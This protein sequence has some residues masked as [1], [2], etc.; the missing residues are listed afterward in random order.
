MAAAVTAVSCDDNNLDDGS[1]S[2]VTKSS[3]TYT[4]ALNTSGA[5][6]VMTFNILWDKVTTGDKQWSY[7]RPS[8]VNLL[9]RHN[10]DI[11]GVQEAFFNQARYIANEIDYKYFGFGMN[12]GLSETEYPDRYQSLN[13]IFYNPNRVILLDKGVFWYSSESSYPNIGFSKGTTDPY[14]RMCVWGKFKENDESGQTFYVFNTHWSTAEESRKKGAVLLLSKIQEIAGENALVICT[15]DFNSDPERDES[16]S[17]ITDANTPLHLVNTKTICSQ[18]PVGPDFTAS[19]FVVDSRTDG[20]E[21]DHI[22]VRNIETCT[23]HK[24]ITDYE[25]DNY[26]SDHWPVLS[27]IEFK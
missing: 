7:R 22:F 20:W 19:G 3:K 6:N 8:L 27:I 2:Q 10:P 16:Y 21:V 26:P 1:N 14:N 24:V 25:G 23:A 12:D 9:N 11:I 13:P 17:I 15:G 18:K 5:L 4:D